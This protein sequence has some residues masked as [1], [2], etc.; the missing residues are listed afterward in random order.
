MRTAAFH[1]V[2]SPSVWAIFGQGYDSV[3]DINISDGT[4]FS[5]PIVAGIA[6]VLRQAFPNAGATQIRNAIVES[7]D[8][9]GLASRFTQ[10]DYGIGF[11]DAKK[12]KAKLA[13]GT[14][15]NSLPSF[16]KPTKSVA[17]NVEEGTGLD[18]LDGSIARATGNLSPGS[19][20]RFSTKFLRTRHKS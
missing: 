5:A 10:L 17:E 8:P 18:I 14:V 15:S 2:W 16:E 19:A 13:A 9:S 11:P 4:S 20:P 7:G 6:A 3:N 12:A 1:Q